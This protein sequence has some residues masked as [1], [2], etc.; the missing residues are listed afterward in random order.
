MTRKINGDKEVG[1]KKYNKLII[2]I[3]KLELLDIQKVSIKL[4]T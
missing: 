1:L 2:F 3:W 4:K